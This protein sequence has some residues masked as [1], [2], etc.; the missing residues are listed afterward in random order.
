[1]K[2]LWTTIALILGMM[3]IL[4]ACAALCLAFGDSQSGGYSDTALCRGFCGGSDPVK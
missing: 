4:T 2:K 1:M 3:G